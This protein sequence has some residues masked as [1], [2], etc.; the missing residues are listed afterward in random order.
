MLG[1]LC[2]GIQFEVAAG[3]AS[4][5]HNAIELITLSFA[6]QP[7]FECLDRIPRYGRAWN[8]K[9]KVR[10]PAQGGILNVCKTLLHRGTA[11]R[12][13]GRHP[14]IIRTGAA[15]LF[16]TSPVEP[17]LNG[18]KK[19]ISRNIKRRPLLR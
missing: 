18:C 19:A 16:P 1:S 13:V 15:S 5:T 6:A 8:P 9:L 4:Y 11:L 14:R 12:T 3:R 7:L 17:G 10:W 2:R